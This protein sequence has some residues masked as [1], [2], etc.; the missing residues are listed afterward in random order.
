LEHIVY[1]PIIITLKKEEVSEV[2]VLQKTIHKLKKENSL[3]KTRLDEL[4]PDLRHYILVSQDD[5]KISSEQLKDVIHEFLTI[6]LPNLVK[7]YYKY[8]NETNNWCI[9]ASKNS[10]KFINKKS[11]EDVIELIKLWGGMRVLALGTGTR[12]IKADGIEVCLREGGTTYTIC[13]KFSKNGHESESSF[14]GGSQYYVIYYYDIYQ[15]YL[16]D[17]DDKISYYIDILYKANKYHTLV[18]YCCSSYMDYKSINEYKIAFLDIKG[19][20]INM[21]DFIN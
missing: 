13:D 12:L 1:D 4:T 9:K 11:M 16:Y 10:Q 14:Y 7:P 17:I 5:I 18:Q 20:H 3:M 15:K 2:L 6:K 19:R 8:D 21:G